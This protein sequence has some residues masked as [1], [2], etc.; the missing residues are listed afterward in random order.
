[1][2]KLKSRAQKYYIFL[3]KKRGEIILGSLLLPFDNDT[4]YEKVLSLKS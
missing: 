3:K 1:M 2:P 4:I